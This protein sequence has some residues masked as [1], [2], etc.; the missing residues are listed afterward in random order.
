MLSIN[1]MKNK[2]IVSDWG[3]ISNNNVHRTYGLSDYEFD[4]I[5]NQY[6]GKLFSNNIE[7]KNKKDAKGFVNYM[8]NLFCSQIL[9]K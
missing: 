3:T 5:V 9:K 1:E 8:N 4:E 2:Y 6:N 7:F